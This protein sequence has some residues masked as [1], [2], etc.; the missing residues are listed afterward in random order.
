MI[1]RAVCP[2][3][4]TGPCGKVVN[5]TLASTFSNHRRPTGGNCSVGVLD[6][7]RIADRVHPCVDC[8][9]LPVGP[10]V[11]VD[12]GGVKPHGPDGPEYRPTRPRAATGRP[13]RCFRHKRDHEERLKA[14]RRA[15]DRERGR[16]ITEADRD[17]LWTAQGEACACCGRRLNVAKR[18]P[19]LDHD[20]A[21]AAEHD[22]PDDQACRRCA[23]GL[24]C[25][26]CNR[27]VIGDDRREPTSLAGRY[28]AG[29][30]PAARLG[31]WNDD[32]EDTT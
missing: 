18:A 26:T 19:T 17:L 6:R 25:Q 15:R 28:V 11:L 1:D 22:H 20:H 31:W 23:R 7:V 5:V 14:A 30:H 24:L 16:G 3:G 13:P 29:D 4:A 2:G 9:A 8:A 21:R 32:T 12:V 27:K 10:G